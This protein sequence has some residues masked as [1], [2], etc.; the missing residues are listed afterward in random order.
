MS[1]FKTEPFAH[2]RALLEETWEREA[3]ALFWEMG[4]GKSWV[5]LNTAARL[6]RVGKI[7]GLTVV[8]PKGVYRNWIGEI[9]AH[10]PDD[11]P[12]TIAVWSPETTKKK[13]AELGRVMLHSESLRVLLVNVEA[14]STA[15]AQ[16]QLEGFLKVSKS[17]L[18]VDES[19]WVKTPK[20]KRTEALVELAKLAPYRRIMTGSAITK[21]PLDLYSQCDV[22]G[23]GLLG[24]RSFYAYK[25]RYAETE[26][27]R[28]PVPVRA[29]EQPKTRE[30]EKVVGFQRIDELKERL[31]GF[32][33][34]LLKSECVD[35]P[36]KIY[37]RRDV[38][39][40]AEQSTLYRELR[41][42]SRAELA[43]QAHVTAPMVI[44]RMLR[45]HQVVCGFVRTDD[46]LDMPL[47]SKRDMAL[48]E[49]LEETSG[50]AIVW[51]PYRFSIKRIAA[52]L[53]EEYGSGAAVTYF[54]DTTD[55]ERS[56]AIQVFQHDPACRFFIG[57]P[58][59][60]GFG[61]TLTAALTVIYFA[62]GHRLEDR[63][64]SE[65]RAHRIGQTQAVTYVDLVASGTV[66]ERIIASLRAKK[67]I[68]G[69]VLGEEWKDW[70]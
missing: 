38:E 52:L 29:G 37:E 59:T 28:V 57:N 27:I 1:E 26:T 5:V 39:L 44:T 21:N 53:A 23:H 33:Q 46:G 13:A 40:T 61:L 42:K 22:L 56:A 36:P 16:K 4:C 35:L 47:A 55:E 67:Q 45:L 50:K 15:R 2:Q 24:F 51:A 48:L 65:D 41:E 19:T 60:A 7:D 64:Q 66:D 9:E 54:G 43:G 6:F 69:E 8:A 58:Q 3:F 70:I 68:A 34:R 31:A 11:V 63:L 32:S 25:N 18:A 62:N 14:M 30:V 10:L 12:R 20:A 49:V 17:L